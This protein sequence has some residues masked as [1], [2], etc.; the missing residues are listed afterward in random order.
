MLLDHNALHTI[1]QDHSLN[2]SA[3]TYAYILTLATASF[4]CGSYGVQSILCIKLSLLLLYLNS[5]L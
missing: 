5:T 2:A 3:E 1:D 4:L